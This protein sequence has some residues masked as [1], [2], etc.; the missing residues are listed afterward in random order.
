MKV[1]I[2]GGAGYIGSVLTPI[3]LEKGHSV[4]VLDNLAYSQDSLL[5][6][7][8]HPNFRFV[9]G[10]A[11]DGAILA[12]LVPGA[13]AVLPLAALV[14]A[15]A[16]DRNPRMA[17]GLNFE[18]VRT[19]SEICSKDQMILFP[20]TNSGYGIGRGD[21][22]CTEDTPL[23]PISLYGKTKVRAESLLL[24]AGN[25]VALRLAT[26]FGVSPRMR[27]D[28]LVN[29]FTYRALTDRVLVIFEG[30]FRRNYIH[31]RDVAATFLFA[32]E[33]YDA[34]KGRPFNVGLSSANLTKLELA[35][36]IK[37]HIP[38]LTIVESSIGSDPDKRDYIVSNERLESLGWRPRYTLDD[39]IEELIKGVSMINNNRYTNL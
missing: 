6:V 21:A 9:R 23:K 36:K 2:T 27:L 19:L 28:L 4:T 5:G 33:N 25:C 3:L 34:M 14:G 31:I 15:P 39:G 35:H 16:C 12:E 38:A 8:Y 18:A 13:D 22:F 29:D 26:V 17:Y 20:N 10:D 32:L 37:E 11:R 30:H 1:L 24:E 7:A